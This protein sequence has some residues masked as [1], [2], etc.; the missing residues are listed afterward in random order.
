MKR[1]IVVFSLALLAAPGFAATPQQEKMKACNAD[2]AKENLQGDAR[3]AFMK[4]CLS[5]KKEAS[6]EKKASTP[7]QVKMT[8][9]NADAKA[10][11]LMG[12]A[13]KKFMKE[14]LSK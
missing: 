2:A 5:A 11:E 14:C 6:A 3:K 8:Q 9:C 1:L 10:K 13:R 7:Q 4:E 12:D